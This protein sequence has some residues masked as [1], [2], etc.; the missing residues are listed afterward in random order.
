MHTL[1]TILCLL[2]LLACAGLLANPILSHQSKLHA[3]T[4]TMHAKWNAL[5]CSTKL[6]AALALFVRIESEECVDYPYALHPNGSNFSTQLGWDS[7]H[8]ET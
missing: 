8:Y 2:G 3:T 6:D 7:N 5:G 4:E 1:E